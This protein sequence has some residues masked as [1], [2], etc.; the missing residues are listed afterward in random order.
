MRTG[1]NILD[2]CME[3]C[4]SA[5]VAYEAALLNGISITDVVSIDSVPAVSSAS[6][7]KLF[8]SRK[9]KP[10][11]MYDS[12]LY[13]PVNDISRVI[14]AAQQQNANVITVLPGQNL[15]DAAM[16]YCG[17]ADMLYQLAVANG[18]SI[19]D[20]VA[21]GDKLLKIDAENSKLVSWW[22][23]RKHKPATGIYEITVPATGI[24]DYTFDFT[25]E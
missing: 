25:F 5:S 10:A 12:A 16:Q 13:M 3:Q 11:T 4:G 9:M 2:I 14:Q 21:V 23:G 6:V 7:V 8:D 22:N 20:T 1:Q 15:I 18:L 19:T 24:F 17:D